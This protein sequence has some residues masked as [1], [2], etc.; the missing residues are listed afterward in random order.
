[1]TKA[2]KSILRRHDIPFTKD[3]RLDCS[4]LVN[5]CLSLDDGGCD[6]VAPL[7]TTGEGASVSIEDPDKTSKIIFKAG[8]FLLIE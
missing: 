1:M 7:G 4:K 2:R 3:Y 8:T 6:G 5:Y